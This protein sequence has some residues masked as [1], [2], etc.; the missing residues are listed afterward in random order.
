MFLRFPKRTTVFEPDD[1][2]AVKIMFPEK[3]DAIIFFQTIL[4]ILRGPSRDQGAEGG[5]VSY[6]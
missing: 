4:E 2:N 6:E 3:D 5:T 1:M